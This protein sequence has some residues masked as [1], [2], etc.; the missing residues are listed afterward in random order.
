L[1]EHRLYQSDFLLR[2]YGFKLPDLIFDERGNLSSESDPKLVWAQ[3]HPEFFPIE[4]NRASKEELLRVPGIG[5]RSA[6]RILHLR[7]Q[8]RFRQ[9]EDLRAIGAVAARAAPF[10]LLNGRHPPQQLTLC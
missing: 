1:R 4:I 7:Q 9:I 3:A 5:P 6:A 2:Y 8:S 10:V